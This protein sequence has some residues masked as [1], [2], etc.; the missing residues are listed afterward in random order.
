M[1]SKDGGSACAIVGIGCRFPGHANSPE[2]FWKLLCEGVDVIRDIPGDRFDLGRFYD[3]DPARP[4]RSY[5]RRAGIADHVGSFDAS[6]FG[7]SR[8]EAA[9]MDPQQR[10]L[11]EVAWEALEDAG[12]P[13][14]RIAG[15]RTGVY[16]GISSHDFASMLVCEA[17]RNRI[18]AHSLTGTAGSIAANRLSYLL[19]LRGPSLA[20]DTA[21]SSSL[22][23]L[24]LACGGLS[25]GEC[26]VALAGGVNLF[27][28]PETAIT[29]AKASM[30]APD[31]R[32]KAFDARANGYVRGEG[33]GIVVLKPLDRALHDRDRIYAVVRATAV[34]QDGRT[35]GMTVPSSEAQAAMIREALRQGAV[36]PD[37]VQYVEAH[38][39]GTPAGDPVE[40]AAIG[41][42]F[43]ERDGGSSC[44]IGSVKTN[45]GH[46]EAAAG[47][48]GLIK[49]ALALQHRMIPPSL[50]FET[51]N[52]AIP[53]ER[54]RLRVATALE[55]W[56]SPCRRPM[57]AVNSFGV[58]GANAHALL[59]GP[60]E[61]GQTP[62]AAPPVRPEPRVLLLSARTPE[63]LA[64]AA[65]RYIEFLRE[66]NVSIDDVCYTAAVRRTH[67]P[68]RLAVVASGR[69]EFAARLEQGASDVITG[70]AHHGGA[71]KLAFVYS[72]MGLQ[73][74]G[75]AKELR[76]SEP[77]FREVLNE[78]DAILRRWAGWSLLGAFEDH[79]PARAASPAVAQVTNFALQA[80]LTELW[81]SWGVIPDA[82]T[83]HS[84]G[85]VAAAYGAGALSLEDGLRLAYHRGRLAQRASGMGGML[86]ASLSV[87]AA[88]A[89][90]SRYDSRIALAAVNSPGSV[91]LSG[92]SD[93]LSDIAA[94]LERQQAF[95]RFVPVTV[96]YHGPALD[97]FR[98]ELIESLRPLAPRK[99]GI[100]MVSTAVGEWVNGVPL[101]AGHWWQEFRS[102]V[103]FARALALLIEDGVEMFLEIG[104]HASLQSP[105]SDCLAHASAKGTVLSSLRRG[106]D[107]RAVMLRAAAALHVRGRRIDWQ[108]VFQGRGRP[109][110]LPLYPWQRESF[111]TGQY[112]EN[113]TAGAPAGMDS[114]H[115]L[116]GVRILSARPCW[117][118]NLADQRLS[119]LE[120]HVVQDAMVFP[121]AAYVETSLAAGAEL[122]PGSGA[123]IEQ[124]EFRKMLVLTE[125]RAAMM[126]WTCDAAGTFEIFSAPQGEASWTLHAAGRVR[127][128]ESPAEPSTI[129]LE[130]VRTRCPQSIPLSGWYDWYRQRGLC[131]A[132]AFRGVE[133][134]WRGRGEALGRIALTGDAS[135]YHIHPGLLDSAFQVL[136]A[137]IHG[138]VGGS[139]MKGTLLPASIGAVRW[140]G[141]G[142]VRLWAYARLRYGRQD[143]FE[144]DIRLAD[145]T[146]REVLAIEGLRCLLV[147]A[148]ARDSGGLLSR[149]RWR[150]HPVET[151]ACAALS[152][153]CAP[154]VEA[155]PRIAASTGIDEYYPRM[156]NS[157]NALAAAYIRAA[158]GRLGEAS[159]PAAEAD[160]AA[161]RERLGVVPGHHRY[162]GRLMEIARE[163]PDAPMDLEGCRRIASGLREAHPAWAG[164]V[165]LLAHCGESLDEMLTGKLEAQ[166]VL[167]APGAIECLGDF[168]CHSPLFS[169]YNQVV[170]EVV[171]ALARERSG[172]AKLRVLELGAG[173]GG[174]TAF[175]LP[176]LAEG[177]ADY[178]FTDISPLFLSRARTRF[179]GRPD[180]HFT[181]LDIETGRSEGILPHGEFDVIIASNVM[182]TAADVLEAIRTARRRLAP[183]GVL[184]L[185]EATRAIAW[186]EFVFGLFRGWWRFADR[187]LR[188]SHP[189]MDTGKW[190]GILRDAGLDD[191]EILPE[192]DCECPASETVIVA[193]PRRGRG[194]RMA[195][196]GGPWR[197]RGEDVP[198]SRAAR[199]DS[200]ARRALATRRPRYARLGGRDSSRE[201]GPAITRKSHGP[202]VDG[203][204]SSDLR[205]DCG[206]A[207]RAGVAARRV[208]SHLAGDRGGAG[209][210]RGRPA[211]QRSAGRPVGT[212]PRIG[213]GV[214]RGALPPGR[215]EPRL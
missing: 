137:A 205:G 14:E 196:P 143:A 171:A 6:F 155:A 127:R 24:H 100:P 72:G 201:P 154:A 69:E 159:I 56:P 202:T 26:E 87:A 16:I 204:S 185:L 73:R 29:M 81:R 55:P 179:T 78:C 76:L 13:V 49:A 99:P 145:D 199:R 59:Q 187:E 193:R 128:T 93:A 9:H 124:M 197:R 2:E 184:I 122:W 210:K 102:P 52:P 126:Q 176:R 75:M 148:P 90:I 136:G 116:L 70:T 88:A 144:G 107:D 212:G 125:G 36:S 32:S 71:P 168:Y 207:A 67:H 74:P 8:R 92:D 82:V 84:V 41:E 120:G 162:F 121:A 38:G 53:F 64:G 163:G 160:L 165:D 115:P 191:V 152:R 86:V 94:E 91:T 114:G 138:D 47:I 131:Y 58:G 105:I 215:P 203:V 173:T 106:E 10:V 189:L 104:P 150:E 134:V 112:A 22:T 85:E 98:D 111:G 167:F 4:G 37:E 96:P 34:N 180:L 65:G 18:G 198:G 118:A 192:L 140:Y 25:S 44:V 50:H 164:M 108:N 62:A 51:P 11:L 166:E 206:S 123:V 7:I 63:A 103:Q 178:V 3:P 80:A 211:A 130:A 35:V 174:T 183:G 42:V 60:P 157:L 12:V 5:V 113:Q 54:L 182:H 129:D 27:L 117:Q 109:V 110:A 83:G 190:A 195:D 43:G 21:C 169:Y 186:T 1:H 213:H 48:A 135:C 68:H 40:A 133:A 45:I 46:L 151:R 101:S 139:A 30:L 61:E 77:V 172:S 19:D 208:A 149:V 20:V 132:G 214:S 97:P 188:T 79:D 200:R 57:A 17:N 181:L 66:R 31:G 156:E 194:R 147:G 89:M 15:S 33:A 158:V 141:P 209:G 39:T 153:L 170:A 23:A 175:V 177:S 119:Y 146:G 95:C 28:A 142:G 161:L